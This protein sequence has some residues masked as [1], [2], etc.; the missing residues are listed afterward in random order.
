[1]KVYEKQLLHASNSKLLAY[2]LR[3]I[4]GGIYTGEG[5]GGWDSPFLPPRITNYNV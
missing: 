2:E 4:H 3:D 1:V 5:E